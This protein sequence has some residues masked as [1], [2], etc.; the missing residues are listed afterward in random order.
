M[1]DSTYLTVDIVHASILFPTLTK[2]E[3]K[4][5]YPKMTVICRE[6]SQNLAMIHSLFG[7]RQT[8]FLGNMMPQA[9]CLEHMNELF[10][11][12]E[13]LGKYSD[14]IRANASPCHCNNMLM[15]HRKTNCWHVEGHHTVPWQP[16]SSGHSW[17]L[18]GRTKQPWCWPNQS[19]PHQHLKPHC[20]LAQ[21]GINQWG[22]FSRANETSKI[23][24]YL[25]KKQK[26]FVGDAGH[27]IITHVMETGLMKDI[28]HEWK[29]I[30]VDKHTWSKLI[31]PLNN[32]FN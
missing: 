18:S 11:P 21:N 24:S 20:W 3:G 2:C 25:Y 6:L 17:R 13:N 8:G 29:Q 32:V 19:S 31:D 28:Y 14:E 15:Q 16:I 12:P 22:K 23:A 26:T 9:L 7:Q 5:I 30:Q 4:Q 1:M 10:A 27:P